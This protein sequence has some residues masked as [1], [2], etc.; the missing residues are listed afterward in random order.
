M[1][2][3][4]TCSKLFGSKWLEK[5]HTCSKWFRLSWIDIGTLLAF[6][7][8]AKENDI[9]SL[10]LLLCFAWYFDTTSTNALKVGQ[11][12][13]IYQDSEACYL[14]FRWC[15]LYEHW[16]SGISNDLNESITCSSEMVFFMVIEYDRISVLDVCLTMD[17]KELW[18]KHRSKIKRWNLLKDLIR[19]FRNKTSGEQ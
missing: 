18:W 12:W 8:C 4:H 15:C 6:N 11:Y 2:K 10:I 1:E 7:A 14:Q 3:K 17:A 5:K 13:N 16:I 19:K 9:Q